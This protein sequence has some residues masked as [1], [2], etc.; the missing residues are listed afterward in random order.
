MH[1]KKSKTTVMLIVV[2]LG[3]FLPYIARLPRG[4]EWVEQYIQGGFIGVLFLSA[5]N[6]NILDNNYYLRD[7]IPPRNMDVYSSSIWISFY[8]LGTFQL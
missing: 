5:F 1:I 3:V 6:A 4:M 8:F 2:I 7:V